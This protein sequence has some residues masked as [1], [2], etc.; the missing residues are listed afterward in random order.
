MKGFLINL[1]VREKREIRRVQGIILLCATCKKI[2][3]ADGVWHAL[4]SSIP[5]H[6]D[7]DFTHGICPECADK[8]FHQIPNG[9][10]VRG[11]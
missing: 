6:S 2:R 1:A 9:K 4:E 7:A 10:V 5:D 8:F 3:G 11:D